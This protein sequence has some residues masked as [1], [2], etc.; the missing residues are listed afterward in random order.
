MRLWHLPH[1]NWSVDAWFVC[2]RTF[3]AIIAS[4][5]L[6]LSSRFSLDASSSGE[7]DKSV[8]GE[9]SPS[10]TYTRPQ[11]HPPI[12][13]QPSARLQDARA[14]WVTL[15]AH[16]VTLRARW[17]MLRAR[18]DH[19]NSGA[20]G[21]FAGEC[22]VSAPPPSASHLATQVR[23]PCVLEVEGD[24]AVLGLVLLAH[25]AELL[26]QCRLDGDPDLRGG[27]FATPINKA[28]SSGKRG[29]TKHSHIKSFPL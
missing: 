12:R 6:A 24:G 13:I 3:S 2:P 22:S 14:H 10:R 4:R 20:H 21:S 28:A 5:I 7:S 15:R 8:Y 1:L 23:I 9:M 17:V 19:I 29:L 27:R 16:W 26:R 11:S 25:A 18:W